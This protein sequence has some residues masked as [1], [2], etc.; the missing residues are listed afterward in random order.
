MSRTHIFIYDEASADR[1]LEREISD[2][3][4]RLAGLGIDGRIARISPLRGIRQTV[5]AMVREGAGTVV[6]IGTD[7][8]FDKVMWFVPDLDLPVG[9][10]PVGGPSL[11]AAALRLPSGVGACD[12]IAARFMETFDVGLIEDRYFLSEVVL[13][14]TF[15]TVELPGRFRA[16]LPTGGSIHVRNLDIAPHDIPADPRD[17]LLDILITPSSPEKPRWFKAA[18][19]MPETRL[20]ATELLITSIEPV[21]ALVDQHAVNG[22]R[23][24]LRILPGKLR[25]ITG[26]RHSAVRP[27]GT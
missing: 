7:A 16:S 24:H 27:N 1:K 26:R 5:E 4:A 20:Q 3:E 9:F 11:F 18:V 17:G 10:V 25:L 14:R 23:F 12:A 22:L 21:D 19:P 8:T 15:A 13:P 2:V 6:V